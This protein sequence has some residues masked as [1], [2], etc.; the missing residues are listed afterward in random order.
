MHRFKPVRFKLILEGELTM[1]DPQINFTITVNPVASALT[2]LDG[3]GNVLT[4]GSTVAL[5][6]DTVG[7]PD[8]GQ[9]LFTVKS[10]VAPYNYVLASGSLPPG[11]QPSAVTN[12]DG[13]ET[14][15]LTGTPTA[16]GA[17]AF[18]LIVTDSASPTP[19]KRTISLG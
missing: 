14:V 2:V 5:K 6:A 3:N 8:P 17:S 12:Q 18:S 7:T 1:A 9:V 16:Q 11:L 19:A 13:S 10:G 4:D 15:S